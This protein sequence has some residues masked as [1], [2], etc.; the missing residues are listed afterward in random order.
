MSAIVWFRQD[1]RVHD[2]DALTQACVNHKHVVA[3]VC[4]T[5]E[6]WK[7][8]DWSAIKLDLYERQ[9]N[10]LQSALAE[11][12]IVLKVLCSDIYADLPN[13]LLT[14]AQDESITALYANRDY[15]L[16]EV[17]RDRAVH[18]WLENNNISCH[19]F[20]SNL[21]V[22]PGSVKPETSAYYQKFTPFF[23]SWQAVLRERGIPGP[24]SFTAKGETFSTTSLKIPRDKIAPQDGLEQSAEGWA[25]SEDVIRQRLR[26][27]ITEQVEDYKKYRDT[28]GISGTSK[29][30]P[31]LELGVV[32]PRFVAHLLQAASPEFPYGLEEGAHTWLSELAWREFYQHL[33]Y[34]V[35]RL[36]MGKAFKEY[37]EQFP[38]RHS[39]EDFRRWR[40]GRTGFPIVDAGMRQLNQTG[41][42]HNRVR[43][44]VA[45]F[46]VKDLHID[47]RWGERYFMQHL[48]DGSYPANNGGWQWSASTG[49]DAVPYFRVFNP[50][51]QSEQVDPEGIYIRKWVKELKD[52]PTKHIHAPQQYL[53]VKGEPADK[54]CI[55]PQPMVNHKDARDRFIETFK[56]LKK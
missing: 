20:D 44:I 54:Y 48:I 27:F 35:P 52:V 10:Y 43:M 9:L 42:M 13:K 19:W 6:Q 55:Y 41:W 26:R 37:T 39:K 21:L 25:G 3:V 32:S 30:S 51:R 47:W 4:C 11:N 23:K 56:G 8:H 22:P 38:W 29:L 46:L 24:S 14:F 1:L 31:F 53:R 33:A 45:N 7:R 15:A 18:A 17:R 16:D 49:T 36:S 2:N 5:P 50:T 34:Q 40:E 12:G 28:P